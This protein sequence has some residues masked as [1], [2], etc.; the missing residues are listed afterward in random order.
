MSYNF[1]L[2][3]LSNIPTQHSDTGIPQVSTNLWV[4]EGSC[5]WSSPSPSREPGGAP[6]RPCRTLHAAPPGCSVCSKLPLPLMRLT[7]QPPPH[8]TMRHGG[9]ADGCM[10]Q[11]FEQKPPT[12]LAWQTCVRREVVV[13]SC[14]TYSSDTCVS[15]SFVP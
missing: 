12:H 15:S 2:F 1:F 7:Q 10:F 4:S 13:L 3:L 8:P 5:W 9:S 11:R 6:C 14:V